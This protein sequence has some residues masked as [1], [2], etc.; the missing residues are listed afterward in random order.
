MGSVPKALE[1]VF[2]AWSTAFADSV[3]PKFMT[4]LKGAVLATG[5]RTVSRILR[6]VGSIADAH[7]SS[8]HRVLSHRRWSMWA[9]ARVLAECVVSAFC[10]TGVIRLAGDETV[11]EHPG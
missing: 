7:P 4:L 2:I 11:T 3:F 1:A 6:L 10:H 9:L 5:C 8:Y